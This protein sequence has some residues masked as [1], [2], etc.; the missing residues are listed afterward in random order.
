MAGPLDLRGRVII[1]DAGATRTLGA[2]QSRLQAIG[3]LQ[4]RASNALVTSARNVQRS[5]VAAGG[6]AFGAY[7]ALRILRGAEDFNRSVFGVGAAAVADYTS[8]V[9]DAST[10]TR[11]VVVDLD[12][13]RK[14]MRSVESDVMSL[15]GE[16]GQTPSRLGGIAEVLA[17]AGFG[18]EKLVAATRAIGQVAVTD[19]ETPVSRLAEF[20]SVL[21]TI[22]KPRAGESWSK[23]FTRQ[24]DIVRIG[25]GETRLSVGSMMEGLRPFSALYAQLGQSEEQNALMLMAGVKA[26]GEATEIGHT[27]KSNAVRFMNMTAPSMMAFDQL[28]LRRGDYMDTAA[29]DPM[30]VT[31]YLA[32]MFPEAKVAGKYRSDLMSR[33]L[34]A[35]KDGTYDDPAFFGSLSREIAKRAK[36]DMNNQESRDAFEERFSNAMFT[37]G[38]R[39]NMLKL[40]RDLIA[41]GATP[42]MMARL[43]EGRRIGYNTQIM[44]GLREFGMDDNAEFPRKLGMASGAGLDATQTIYDESA[45]GKLQRFNAMLEKFQ[46]TLSQSAGFE[47]FLSG[48]TRMFEVLGQLPQP[49]L[50][51]ASTAGVLALA[52][53]PVALAFSAIA[54]VAGPLRWMAGIAGGALGLS[55]GAGMAGLFGTAGAGAVASTKAG[56]ALAA[57]MSVAGAAAANKKVADAMISGMSASGAAGAGAAGAAGRAGLWTGAKALGRGA[58]RFIPGLGMAL[59]VGGAAYGGYR[60]YSDGGGVGDVAKGAA[61]GAI[62]LDS[63]AQAA[64]ASQPGQS[65]SGGGLEVQS[66]QALAN[67]RATAEQIK[68][69]LTQG[70]YEA[71]VAA[72]AQF[73]AGITAGGAQAVAAASSVASRV[74]SATSNTVPLNTGPSMRGAN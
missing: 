40:M 12:A 67:A 29:A 8:A 34:K 5:W 46:I 58:L 68:S 31:S 48:I 61:L 11:K 59:M 43:F 47:K 24:M 27:L 36:I 26:G 52:L 13:V 57:G 33:M 7:G 21:D 70:M 69:I 55:K 49:V 28:G 74:R 73:A 14:V 45:Y 25:A 35:Q 20:A 50:D 41:K 71:G 19:L 56:R 3:T 65:A 63:T 62:G 4:Q 32:R 2:V 72:M 6:A 16:L 60:A 39:V 15:S 17:K 10:G 18:S 42:D 53:G 64:E 54:A 37:A 66:Q 30:K 23:F 44:Q 51:F 22:Y 1:A 9:E 38:T